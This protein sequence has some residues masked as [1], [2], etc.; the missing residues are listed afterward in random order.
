MRNLS[1][2]ALQSLCVCGTI[3]CFDFSLYERKIEIQKI[4]KHHLRKAQEL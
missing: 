2:A 3:L 4:E 1:F